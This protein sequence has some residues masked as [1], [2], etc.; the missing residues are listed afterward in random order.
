MSNSAAAN[1]AKFIKSIF[2]ENES[3]GKDS[4]RR[5]LEKQFIPTEREKKDYAEFTTP[6]HLVDSMLDTISPEFWEKPHTVFEP[7]CGK[8]AF[9]LAI[10][11]RF[12][13]S[14][15]QKE[16]TTLEKCRRIIETCIYFGDIV[17]KNVFITRQ[18]LLEY[19]KY[20][21]RISGESES[22]PMVD[23]F[24][25]HW[26]VGDTTT[27][28]PTTFFGNK[29]I[30]SRFDAVIGN[31]P[32]STDPALPHPKQL[33]NVFVTTYMEVGDILLFVI[34]S[35]W[36]SG[37]KHLQ[38]FRK[39]MQS[40]CDIVSITHIDDS[41]KWF[42][43]KVH[44]KGG[45][46]YFLKDKAH[47]GDCMFN[48]VS[49]KL[50]KYSDCIIKP[51]YHPLIDQILVSQQHCNESI[52][53]LYKGRCFHIE[54]NDE[55]IGDEGPIKCYVSSKKDSFRIKYIQ[56]YEFNDKNTFWKV[57]TPESAYWEYS[58]FG[59]LFIAGPNEVHTGSYVCF[60]VN[61]EQEAEYLLSYLATKFA[62]YLLS[63]RKI[64]QH[65]NPQCL[66]WIPLVPL[67]RYWTDETV[68]EYF[69]IDP[70]FIGD[71]SSSQS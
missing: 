63:I 50:D 55:R 59:E 10:F 39:F 5:A 48:G 49:Y 29:N 8:G 18:I 53:S 12:F 43:N 2:V 44:I 31:P 14:M 35:R 54:T 25:C 37:G 64:S 51:Q 1:L 45:C 52:V 38:S 68:C 56:Q 46:C 70:A 30:V 42:G 41:E 34:P 27:F 67:D 36:F 28:S 23:K 19:C 9:V 58:G 61:S 17:E 47:S 57:I 16:T 22:Q 69:H 71:T 4:I 32:Y 15:K 24:H 7:C 20:L 21:L 33:Y 62:N 6:I 3:K 66:K 65:I 40:R 11:D 13:T 60:R 26:F